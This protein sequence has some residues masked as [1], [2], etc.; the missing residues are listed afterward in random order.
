MRS[1]TRAIKR[2]LRFGRSDLRGSH[3]DQ[4]LNSHRSYFGTYS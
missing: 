2:L 4:F 3:P 1:F